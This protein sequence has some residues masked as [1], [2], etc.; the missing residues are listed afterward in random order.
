MERVIANT[1][2]F[3]LIKII[4][5]EESEAGEREVEGEEERERER[6]SSSRL[7]AEHVPNVGL[8]LMTQQL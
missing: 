4:Y 1:R 8:D 5:W 3:L 6:E 7:P 2:I